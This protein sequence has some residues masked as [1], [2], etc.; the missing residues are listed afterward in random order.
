MPLS[1]RTRHFAA[2]LATLAMLFGALAP[3][4]AQVVAVSHGAPGWVQVCSASGMLW[5]RIDTETARNPADAG[6]PL[7]D[8]ARHCPWCK[9]HGAAGLPPAPL[10]A[11]HVSMASAPPLA[12]PRSTPVRTDWPAAQSR[13]PPLA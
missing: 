2:W 7:V 10:P 12:I 11:F 1:H 4:A 5:V 6:E 13:A 9:L 8:G 3:A